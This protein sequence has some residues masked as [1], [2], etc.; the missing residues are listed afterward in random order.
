MVKTVLIYQ[1]ING[2]NCIIYIYPQFKIWIIYNKHIYVYPKSRVIRLFMG[3]SCAKIF[4][5]IS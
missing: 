3:A 5:R 1:L 2:Q 4:S